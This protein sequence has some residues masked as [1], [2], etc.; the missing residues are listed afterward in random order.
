MK[1]PFVLL[2]LLIL[3]TTL[4]AQTKQVYTIKADSTKLTGCDSNELIIEN[5]TR[6]VPGFLFNTG[7]GRTQ[8]KRGVIKLNDSFYL[9]GGDT[10]RYNAWIQGGNRWGRIGILGTM[11]S[12]H[13]DLYTNNQQR[14]RLT[15]TGRL[16]VG[17]TTDNAYNNVQVNGSIYSNFFTNVPSPL[18]GLPGASGAIRLRWGTGDGAYIGFYYQGNANKRAYIASASDTRNLIIEDSVGIS[19]KNTPVVNIGTEFG[20]SNS[21]KLS[22]L[23]PY[24]ST[25]DAFNTGRGLSDASTVVDLAV[26]SN[27]NVIVGS[28]TDNGTKLQVNGGGRFNLVE[29][30]FLTLKAAGSTNWFRGLDFNITD[31][32]G[33]SRSYGVKLVGYNGGTSK[34]LGLVQYNSDRF[35]F[36]GAYAFQDPLL[37]VGGA[38]GNYHSDLIF[39]LQTNGMPT[40]TAMKFYAM[41]YS[42]SQPVMSITQAGMIGI[43]TTTP[44][45]QLHTT[46]GVRFAG[47]TNDSTQ[48][49]VLVSDAN[50]NLYYRTA[51]SLA[52]TD[53]LRSSL[54]VNGTIHAKELKLSR[55]GWPDYVFD[56]TYQL[57]P[58][59]EVEEYIRKNGHLPGIPSA[60]EVSRDGLSVGENQEALTKKVEELTLYTIELEK[61]LTTQN[62][63]MELLQQ[64]INDLKKERH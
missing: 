48:T 51:S 42:S 52:A 35:N 30:Q 41:N 61:K 46:G 26:K 31:S 45:V 49:R 16:L 53:M 55:E 50:G 6:N 18:G 36:S 39:T 27:G 4:Q 2:S 57:S 21:A 32:D 59:K 20:L 44:T 1:H 56:S 12:N 17:T 10:L 58:L 37:L 43:G 3:A 5:H 63:M 34:A 62:K 13:L 38:I 33:V 60:T 7:N 23:N 40:P 22:I 15:N 28:G 47:L 8:F 64:Q 9:I 54:A 29:G 24:G 11:D 19:F 14:L 25:R